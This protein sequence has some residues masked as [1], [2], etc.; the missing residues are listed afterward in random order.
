MTFNSIIRI[1]VAVNLILVSTLSFSSSNVN[2]NVK[3]IPKNF[4]GKWAGMHSTKKKLTKSILN[5]LCK[6]GGEQDTSFFV[7]FNTD[8]Q[9]LTSV[10]WWEDLDTE[11]P[12]SY[13]K[14]TANHISGQSLSISFEMGEEDTLASKTFSSFEY[15]ISNGKL[16]VG[17]GTN[18][19]EMMR[20]D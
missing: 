14:Y 8:G 2:S 16:Y 17:S 13:R 11:Y 19:I 18:V 15:K 9:R 1:A 12:V 7:D 6:N 4:I 10:S 5:D 3:P 20:C